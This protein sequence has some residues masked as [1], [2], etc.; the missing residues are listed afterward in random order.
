G[1]YKGHAYDEERGGKVFGTVNGFAIYGP[2]QGFQQAVDAINGDSLGDSTEFKDVL[3]KLPDDRLGTF[4]AIPRT[5]LNAIPPRQVDPARRTF[6]EKS[7]GGSLD[8]P[9]AG[10]LPPT[11][12]SLDLQ[13]IGAANGVETPES[14]LIGDVPAQSWLAVGVA[15]LGDV[16][17]RTLDQVKDQIQNYNAVVQQIQQ[18]TG[19]SL[20][21][22]TGSLG[23]AALY[24]QGTTGSTL[25]AALVVQTTNPDLTGR[26]L[27]QFQT[28]AQ[29]GGAAIKPLRL[30]GGGTGFQIKDRSF[31]TAPVELAQQGD[32]L[33]I[34]YGAH[35][36]ERTLTPSRTLNDS[37]TFSIAKGQVSDLGTDFFLDFR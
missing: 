34:G 11:P 15:N 7:G 29:L 26:L 16:V 17:K 35:S 1:T 19:S 8:K 27:A 31:A 21:Q 2:L 23:D 30:S 4:Y 24:V 5:L 12:D 13:L 20:D 22:L 37:P 28:L 36:A 33:V 14:S 3:G 18:S 9:V 6:G 32:R 10:A 25:T